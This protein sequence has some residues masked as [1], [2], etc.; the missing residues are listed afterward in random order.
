VRK[1]RLTGQ[2]DHLIPES[3]SPPDL[4][5]PT[6]SGLSPN[7]VL[8]VTHGDERPEPVGPMFGDSSV[9][10]RPGPE[11]PSGD[12]GLSRR[13]DDC[14]EQG[15]IAL[16]GRSVPGYGAVIAEI[17]V[18]PSGVYLIDVK[19]CRRSNQADGHSPSSSRTLAPKSLLSGRERTRIMTKMAWQM[20]VVRSVLDGLSDARM[21]PGQPML[22]LVD[23]KWGPRRTP[24]L[25][26]GIYVAWPAKIAKVVSRGGPLSRSSIERIA[27]RLAA[28]LPSVTNGAALQR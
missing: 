20:E 22:A 1:F 5:F 21:A 12:P 7:S 19:H 4:E 15:V 17:A 6:L 18:S 2:A 11:V 8:G 26:D 3:A 13:L 25:I 24:L 16:H 27:E 28:E 10:T 14:A 9:L 23:A